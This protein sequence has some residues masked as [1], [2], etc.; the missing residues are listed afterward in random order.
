MRTSRTGN[1]GIRYKSGG[2]VYDV[3]YY[4]H[5]VVRCGTDKVVSAEPRC[6]YRS[7]FVSPV[8][9]FLN[10]PGDSFTTSSPAQCAVTKRKLRA[11]NRQTSF[12]PSGLLI[13]VDPFESSYSTKTFPPKQ[14]PNAVSLNNRGGESDITTKHQA[15]DKNSSRRDPTAVVFFWV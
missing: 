9:V 15:V 2:I 10:S 6:I 7:F 12:R 8:S 11:T 5:Q 4:T 14:S 13:R 3:K 1:R